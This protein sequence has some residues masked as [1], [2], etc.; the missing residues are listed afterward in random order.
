MRILYVLPYVPSLIRVRP[1]Y[2]IRELAR[3]HELTVLAVAPG[4]EEA[5]AAGM[6]GLG[7]R[8]ETVPLRMGEA[9]RRC[10]AAFWSG[11][12]LQGAIC[13]S[14]EM[15]SRL[16]E[17]LADGRYDVVHLEHFR[18]AYLGA[19]IPPGVPTL[20]DA[21]DCISLLQ[22]RTLRSS[23]SFRQRLLARLELGR[24]RAYEA[25]VLRRF[26]QTIVTSPEDREALARL[27]PDAPI[28]VVPN[29]VDLE[30][31]RPPESPRPA[32]TLIFSGKMSYHA[33]VTAVLHFT[34]RILPLIRE[35]HPAVRL[36][37]AGSDPPPAIRELAADPAITVTGRLPDLRS[38]FAA[39]TVAVCPV[40]VKVG[41]QNK[42]LEA[43]A[44]GLPVVCSRE[45][46]AGLAARDGRDFLVG[47]DAA[48][49]AD[50][51]SRLLDDPAW[52][53]RIG[54]AGR[55]FVETSHRWSAAADQLES[56]YANLIASRGLRSTLPQLPVNAR[57]TEVGDNPISD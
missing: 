18:A 38:A 45:G 54:R 57:W 5:D 8:V 51:V 28:S 50:R 19:R 16:T 42:V 29:G 23:H 4:R 43:M 25:R 44:V 49:F 15:E 40:T 7:A 37:V 13:R 6:R 10:G 53:E 34:R 55:R 27:A 31:F 1:Y 20:Y 30:Y 36:V 46:A 9:L 32:D 26:G 47:D 21:V 35:R 56:L 39:A 3:R 52:R 41:I 33:N 11:E 12:P 24:T 14:R 2:F 22:E 17:L 48:A